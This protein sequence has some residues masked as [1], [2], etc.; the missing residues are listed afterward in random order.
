[1]WSSTCR[2]VLTS[3]SAIPLINNFKWIPPQSFSSCTP[4][5]RL[6]S[7]L[8]P[9]SPSSES[10]A[11]KVNPV[12]ERLFIQIDL[13]LRAHQPAVLKSYAWFLEEVARILD[14]G[15]IV[16]EGEEDPHKVRKTLLKPVFAHSKHR[17]QYEMRTY[18]W[19]IQLSQLTQSTRDTYL[20]YVQRNL[21]EGVSMVVRNHEIR[22]LPRAILEDHRKRELEAQRPESS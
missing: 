2:R 13:E 15:V 21:P 18:Y 6:S 5:L 14:V 11:Q 3:R 20:E 17:V 9:S 7:Q 12:P 16:S 10:S 8:S 22:P 19:L 1:M 4:L